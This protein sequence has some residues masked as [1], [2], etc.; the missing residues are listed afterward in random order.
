MKNELASISQHAQQVIVSLCAGT[1]V[2]D[3]DETLGELKSIEDPRASIAI[4]GTLI[5]FY[6]RPDTAGNTYWAFRFIDHVTGKRVEGKI[7]NGVESN[8]S[9]SAYKINPKQYED[10]A[11]SYITIPMGVREFER[12]IKDF[13][14]VSS[15]P[16]D[17]AKYV[18]QGI[19]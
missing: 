19:K 13:P 7:G 2:R 1:P 12:Y 16:E 18:L 4:W 6:S 15:G 14:H 17:I 3:V 11:I 10:H 5:G 8:L 9:V